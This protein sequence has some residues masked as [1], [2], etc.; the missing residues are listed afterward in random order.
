MATFGDENHI[1]H[2]GVHHIYSSSFIIFDQSQLSPATWNELDTKYKEICQAK[3]QKYIKIFETMKTQF[4]V[5]W[6]K[7][8]EEA[9]EL[10]PEEEQWLPIAEPPRMFYGNC[11]IC[12]KAGQ[13]GS[14]CDRH[15]DKLFYIIQANN[16]SRL[17]NPL[18]LAKAYNQLVQHSSPYP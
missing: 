5:S 17:Y 18:F 15:R 12:K 9:G 7:W 14:K 11:H 16:D 4:D 1:Y 2:V 10:F 6:V 8:D 3:H 13:L